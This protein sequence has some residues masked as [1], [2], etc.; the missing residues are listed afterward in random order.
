MV[1]CF[2]SFGY[3]STD[4]FLLIAFFDF[5][6][7]RDLH[8]LSYLKQRSRYRTEYNIHVALPDH[9]IFFTSEVD[10]GLKKLVTFD[11]NG[12]LNK[13]W[14]RLKSAIL[15]AARSTFPK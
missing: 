1:A 5:L 10:L 8:A 11:D 7:I 6:N 13:E 15:G 3:V 12:H 14:H 4:H 9:K 2:G